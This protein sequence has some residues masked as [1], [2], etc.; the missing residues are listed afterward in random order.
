MTAKRDIIKEL[1]AEIEALQNTILLQ[2]AEIGLLELRCDQANDVRRADRQAYRHICERISN[3]IKHTLSEE[4]AWA[5]LKD[6]NDKI[7]DLQ[8]VCR[9]LD[10]SFKE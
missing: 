9:V 4:F 1:R 10:A 5:I 7:S 3:K 8:D 2:R 6:S